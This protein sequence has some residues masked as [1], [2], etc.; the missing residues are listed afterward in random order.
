[1]AVEHDLVDPEAFELRDRRADL[2]RVVSMPA[3]MDSARPENS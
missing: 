3:T 1:V 2:A